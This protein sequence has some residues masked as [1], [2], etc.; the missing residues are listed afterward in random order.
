MHQWEALSAHLASWFWSIA[1]STSPELPSRTAH[2]SP[3]YLR[4]IARSW[5][6]DPCWTPRRPSFP[7]LA[8]WTKWQWASPNTWESSLHL[9]A[10]SM[11]VGIEMHLYRHRT[12]AHA[13]W[14]TSHRSSWL[15]SISLGLK[16]KK[17]GYG[18]DMLWCKWRHELN[19]MFIIDC[20]MPSWHHHKMASPN[21]AF[22][23]VVGESHSIV[24]R[25]YLLL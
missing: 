10:Y 20:H 23:P 6:Y 2:C 22:H 14:S 21:R 18:D 7:Y 3:N 24:L 9:C 12:I 4:A 11:G 15:L 1:W 13:S 19:A 8:Q 5:T 25:P 16:V 17:E